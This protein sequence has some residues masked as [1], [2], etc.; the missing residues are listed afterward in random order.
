MS[1]NVWQPRTV[2]G[3]PSLTAPRCARIVAP[4]D[5]SA[6]TPMEWREVGAAPDGPGQ[7]RRKTRRIRRRKSAQLRQQYEQ[8][9][10]EAHA[11]GVREGEAPARTRAAAEVQPAIERL[12][13]SIAELAQMRAPP[14][15]AGGRR[16]GQAVAR[17]RPTRAAA[18]TGDGSRRD[19][20]AG[21]RGARKTA[22]A[23]DS[24]ACAR[25]SVAR[26]GD[27]GDACGRPRRNAKVEVIPDGSLAAGRGGVRNQ[28]RQSRCLRGFAA[29]G[30]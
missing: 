29:S 25:A 28:P 1:S 3:R 13:R 21:D 11:A 14:A 7:K 10:R 6:A 4:E 12:A 9:V 20:R 30:N 17:H 23:G 27:R 18:R 2:T 26:G 22:G 5:E 19:A 8:R 15:Q 16:H 24:A